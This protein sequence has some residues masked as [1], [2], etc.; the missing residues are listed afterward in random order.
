MEISVEIRSQKCI[1]D[2]EK[3]NQFWSET[4]TGFEP[5]AFKLKLLVRVWLQQSAVWVTGAQ[6][7]RPWLGWD[8]TTTYPKVGGHSAGS[9]DP[10]D[11]PPYKPSCTGILLLS[12]DWGKRV[13][14][15]HWLQPLGLVRDRELGNP[16]TNYLP[17]SVNTGLYTFDTG[18]CSWFSNLRMAFGLERG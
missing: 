12:V 11:V 13:S 4:V 15:G 18:W 1:S 9:L 14:R 5:Q 2:P 10:T 8:W 17:L 6:R 16:K 7:S 3:D